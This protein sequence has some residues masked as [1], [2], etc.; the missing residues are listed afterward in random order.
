MATPQLP[1]NDTDLKLARAFGALLEKREEQSAIDDPLFSLLNIYKERRVQQISY[2]TVDSEKLWNAIEQQTA[3]AQKSR[4]IFMR[5]ATGRAVIAA[6]ATV[7]IAALLGIFYYINQQPQLVA[8]SKAKIEVI[9]LADGSRVTL[10]PYSSLHKQ[11]GD[12]G[13]RSYRLSGEAYF[14]VMADPEH[15]FS[16]K[17]DEG[18]VS[19]L[20]TRFNLSSWGHRTQLFLEEGSVRFQ[21][22][23]SD[24]A[25]TLQPGESAAIQSD[26]LI[27]T[28][29]AATA[30]EYTDWM[31]RE[32]IF[33]NRT[34]GYVFSELEQ[35]FAISIQAL[36]STRNIVVG[37]RLSL[38][39]KEE[40]LHDLAVV[41][42]GKFEQNST[43]TYRFIPH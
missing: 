5:S 22:L 33:R 39:D 26:S 19:V 12:A 41:L 3:P 29:N 32:L 20:G 24:K 18:N 40:S 15:I 25:V 2:S 34:A 36:D 13:E 6:A 7:L 42:G 4:V 23:N 8:S 21:N 17:T 9:T 43:N 38:A 27:V 37:G 31:N 28:E 11:P 30:N 14:Q 10:R 16:V 1:D 35:Q